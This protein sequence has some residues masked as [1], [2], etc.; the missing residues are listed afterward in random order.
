MEIEC[1]IETGPRP[2]PG[3]S[4]GV[5]D[6]DRERRIER[7]CVL[8]ASSPALSAGRI[9]SDRIGSDRIAR[10]CALSC[11]PCSAECRARAPP[12]LSGMIGTN[13]LRAYMHGFFLDNRLYGK[14]AALAAPFSYDAYR[15]QKARHPAAPSHR[16]IPP[17]PPPPRCR[18]RCRSSRAAP[19]QLQPPPLQS[20]PPTALLAACFPV[21]P[22][23][24]S[25]SV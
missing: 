17:L 2:G 9:G 8:A 20:P 16:A 5:C 24:L 4:A 13:M 23:R 6:A 11:T 15:Q 18:C 3:R 1:L 21:H 10:L 7:L 14:A 19:Q 12:G 25:S 22:S